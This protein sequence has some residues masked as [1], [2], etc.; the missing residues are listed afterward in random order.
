[1]GCGADV[2]IDRDRICNDWGLEGFTDALARTPAAI[3]RLLLKD[4][5]LEVTL[6]RGAGRVDSLGGWR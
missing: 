2:E 4:I 5:S 3:L 1:M 6:R